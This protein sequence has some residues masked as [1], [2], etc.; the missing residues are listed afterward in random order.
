MANEFATSPD[1]QI[2]PA[3][4][5]AAVVPHATDPLP[6][7]SKALYVGGAG[8]LVVRLVD[9]SADVTFVGVAAGSIVPIRAT[10]VR[11]TGT[12]TNI[13]NLY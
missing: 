11:D 6:N 7:V 1:E 8:D 13:V 5:A 3:R 12:A 2:S 10:F 9:D 4:N